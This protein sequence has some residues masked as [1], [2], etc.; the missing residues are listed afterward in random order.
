[1]YTIIGSDQREYGPVP[2]EEVKRWI[3]EGRVNA[4][5]LAKSES[6][7]EWKPLG[8]YPEFAD[9]LAQSGQSQP[10]IVA[11]F[12]VNQWSQG[13]LKRD[14]QLRVGDCLSNAFNLYKENFGLLF[15]AS[16]IYILIIVGCNLLGFIPII[17]AVFSLVLGF[18]SAI[19]FGGICYIFISK[20]RGR[21]A[22]IEDLFYCFK[23]N[24]GQI[25]LL[26][27]VQSLLI[28]ASAL[29][30]AVIAILSGLG[31]LVSKSTGVAGVGIFIGVIVSLLPLIYLSICWLYTIPLVVDKQLDFWTALKVSL[32][33]V[34]QHWF[35]VLLLSLMISLINLAGIMLIGIGFFF[36]FP[37]AIGAYIYSYENIF[38]GSRAN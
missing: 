15:G 32:K 14:Y 20:S 28:L 9:I 4:Q 8:E 18:L 10:P 26:L 6:T 25:V 2:A 35:K 33:K 21:D 34:N 12:D 37:L 31:G 24:L 1:M 17:G 11:D 30:G 22:Q 5:T 36:S 19:L 3:L 27:I 38:G 16:S 23:N 7:V 29:P 13:I